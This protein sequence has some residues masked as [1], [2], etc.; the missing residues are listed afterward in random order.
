MVGIQAILMANSSQKPTGAS[1]VDYV[2]I[3]E[4]LLNEIFFFLLFYP[5]KPMYSDCHSK[6][7]LNLKASYINN[8]SQNLAEDMPLPFQWRKCSLEMFIKALVC[9]TIKGKK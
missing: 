7:S 6:I 4:E 1:V 3:S 5:F 9:P 8:K 2:I